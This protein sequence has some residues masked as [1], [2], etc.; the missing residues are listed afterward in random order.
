MFETVTH[1]VIAAP[2]TGTVFDGRACAHGHCTVH[3][4]PGIARGAPGYWE[5]HFNALVHTACRLNDGAD[6]EDRTQAGAIIRSAQVCVLCHELMGHGTPPAHQVARG[7]AGLGADDVARVWNH[8]HRLPDEDDSA[9]SAS[10]LPAGAFLVRAGAALEIHHG[11]SVQECSI[12]GPR[13]ESCA[14]CAAAF[15]AAR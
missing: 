1:R 15:E 4:P 6:C 5:S 13:A 12:C 7:F 11:S 8:H 3:F 10:D 14:G 9:I 2:C